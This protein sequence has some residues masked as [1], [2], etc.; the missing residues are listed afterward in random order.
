MKL[1]NYLV[2]MVALVFLGGMTGCGKGN[3]AGGDDSNKSSSSN[4][5]TTTSGSGGAVSCQY[6]SIDCIDQMIKKTNEGR[7]A[8]SSNGKRYFYLSLS[9]GLGSTSSSFQYYG[10][11]YKIFKKWGWCEDDNYDY[12]IGSSFDFERKVISSSQVERGTGDDTS[13][14]TNLVSLKSQLVSI[15]QKSKTLTTG[16]GRYWDGSYKSYFFVMQSS[17]RFLVEVRDSYGYNNNYKHYIIDLAYPL[18]ANPIYYYNGQSRSGYTLAG[19]S[20]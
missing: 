16:T 20:F 1:S 13:L 4:S 10:T 18:A 3:S 15:L 14:S 9:S 7:F 11:C 6:G 19:E 8:S 17:T 5:N 12:D 2:L